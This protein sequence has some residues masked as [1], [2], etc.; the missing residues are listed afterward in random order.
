MICHLL[1]QWLIYFHKYERRW[2]SNKSS[3]K[4]WNNEIQN[5]CVI[6][7]N[8]QE[9]SPHQLKWFRRLFDED[10]VPKITSTS[11]FKL[12]SKEGI[13]LNEDDLY[14]IHKN[15]VLY[16]ELEGKSFNYGQ[17]LDQFQVLEKVG[18]GGFGA[19]YKVWDKENSKIYAMKT[20]KIE[21][22]I[23]KASKI[24]ELFREQ[25]TL[26]QLDHH[27]IIRLHHAFQ[28]GE[29]IWLIMDYASG[30]EFEQYLW[31]KTN[32]R[33]SE[34]EA[35]YLISQIWRAVSYCHQ[36]GIIHR[37]L[38]P[39]NI[40]VTYASEGRDN[41]IFI[42]NLLMDREP[43]EN[44]VLKVSDFGIAGIKRSGEKGEE[45][46]AG[47]AKFMAPELHTGKDISANKELDI[48]AIGLILYIMVFGYHPFKVKDREKTIKNIIEMKLKFPP[49][50]SVTC[51]F[52]DLIWKMLDKNP[53]TRINMY[54]ILNHPW[55]DLSDSKIDEVSFEK[56][57]FVKTM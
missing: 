16:L 17:I 56:G 19:V 28:V 35:R 29:D 31:S 10:W 54:N 38:K 11:D 12:Y 36:K 46:N 9:F 51:E 41:N 37:D 2:E 1:T 8:H 30:G 14:F 25:K 22:Y 55:F 57:I 49:E 7:S 18:Q 20:L 40:L 4:W 6:L 24:E 47:T 5:N 39:E 23:N 48:W 33:V 42:D 21:E 32:W 15:D 34:K 53:N 50:V 13:E 52:K 44:I 26:K 43:Y 3:R 27:H 45:S